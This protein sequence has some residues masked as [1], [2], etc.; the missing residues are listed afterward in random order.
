MVE[1]KSENWSANISIQL[2]NSK[3]ILPPRGDQ[4]LQVILDFIFFI[5]PHSYSVL[6]FVQFD[7]SFHSA[8]RI[9]LM[10]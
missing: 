6:K 9:P 2:T 3:D 7:P 10:F 1:N 8:S 4:Y 5:Y